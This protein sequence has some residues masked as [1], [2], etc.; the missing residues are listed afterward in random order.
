MI[1][2]NYPPGAEFDS[3]APWNK[4]EATPGNLYCFVLDYESG[5][6][7]RVTVPDNWTSEQIE[8]YLQDNQFKLSEIY[9]MITTN[10]TLDTW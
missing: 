7:N 10:K 2:N 9:Y 8:E 5:Q 3:S 4:P 6:C 1:N